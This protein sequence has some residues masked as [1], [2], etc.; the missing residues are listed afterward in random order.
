VSEEDERG[1]SR[2]LAI[3]R[4]RPSRPRHEGF[5]TVRLGDVHHGADHRHAFLL[6]FGIR[7]TTLLSVEYISAGLPLALL[8]VVAGVTGFFFTREGQSRRAKLGIVILSILL[9][10]LIML[11]VTNLEDYPKTV[12][13]LG[14]IL[15]GLTLAVFAIFK[16][17]TRRPVRSREGSIVRAAV[18]GLL[19]LFMVVAAST[20]GRTVY[21]DLL[22]TVGGGAGSTISFVTDAEN[23]VVLEELVPM[24]SELQ[25]EPVQLIRETSDSYLIMLADKTSVSVNK[26]L[27][28]G[29]IHPRTSGWELAPSIFD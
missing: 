29:V 27:V 23:G 18:Y 19:F 1:G 21:D 22:S 2:D 8:F 24:R 9:L 5:S 13:T 11:Y 3:D 12:R 7:T 14:L 15:G 6:T 25:T 16:D 4:Q 26:A 20:Y 10:G 17:F 28:K